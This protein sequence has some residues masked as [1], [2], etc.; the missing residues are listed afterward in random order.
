MLVYL[1][2]NIILTRYSPDELYHEE[3]KRLLSE[4][5]RGNFSAVT[6]VLKFCPKIK[7]NFIILL[8]AQATM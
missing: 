3:A 2:T 5:E 6:S 4:I 7:I 1:D 8:T